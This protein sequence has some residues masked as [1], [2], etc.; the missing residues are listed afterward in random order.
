MCAAVLADSLAGG[1]PGVLA[2]LSVHVRVL[3][4]DPDRVAERRPAGAALALV[5]GVEELVAAAAAL[6][7]AGV[8]AVAAIGRGLG[9]A[10]R[11]HGALERG[12]ADLGEEAALLRVARHTRLQRALAPGWARRAAAQ[13]LAA[14]FLVLEHRVDGAAKVLPRGPRLRLRVRA[15]RGERDQQQRGAHGAHPW[16]SWR[17]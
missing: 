13:G 7:D 11:V 6:E 14:A 1:D 12:R 2:V 5:G 3:D 4:A 9:A 10:G 16:R 17:N 8:D 15:L